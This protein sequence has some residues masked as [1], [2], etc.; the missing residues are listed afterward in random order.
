MTLERVS[1]GVK[2]TA[3]GLRGKPIVNYGGLFVWLEEDAGSAAED[4]DRSRRRCRTSAVERTKA[5]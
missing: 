5:N 3:E 1:D 2:V 4:F